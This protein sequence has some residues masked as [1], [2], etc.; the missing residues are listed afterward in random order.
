MKFL[1]KMVRNCPKKTLVTFCR[2]R[3]FSSQKNSLFT[4]GVFSHRVAM[5]VCLCVVL[6]FCAIGCSFFTPLIGEIHPFSKMAVTF[7][8]LTG[9]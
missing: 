1:S 3:F 5:S 2:S 9:F 7:E 4:L 8:P 6:W